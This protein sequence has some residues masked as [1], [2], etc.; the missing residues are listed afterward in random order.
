[1]RYKFPLMSQTQIGKLFRGTSH[2]VGRWLQE[3]GLRNEDGRPTRQA[4]QEGYCEQAPSRGQGYYWAWR[5]EKTVETLVRAGHRP[6]SPPPVELVE[7]SPLAGPFT[8]RA[9]SEG[10]TEIV[11]GDGSVSIVVTGDTNAEW[12]CRMLNV[13]HGHGLRPEPSAGTES[14]V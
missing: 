2:Q 7:P 9:A 6:V 14:G 3:A 13:A 4:L 8:R 11:N 5:P 10:T 1:M 12:L